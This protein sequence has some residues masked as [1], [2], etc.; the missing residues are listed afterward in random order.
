MCKPKKSLACS[1]L[2]NPFPLLLKKI[3]SGYNY[4]ESNYAFSGGIYDIGDNQRSSNKKLEEKEKIMKMVKT[5]D[6]V[7]GFWEINEA[8]KFLIEKYKQE[9]EKLKLEYSK[10]KVIITVL[11]IYY[12]NKECFELISELIMIIKKAKDFIQKETNVGYEDIVEKL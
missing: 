1:A 2:G 4:K 3:N 9:Y 10:D 12:L 8:T 5:Q 7:E 6:F 11:M